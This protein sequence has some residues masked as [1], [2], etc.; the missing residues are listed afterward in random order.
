VVRVTGYR[1]LSDNDVE[2]LASEAFWELDFNDE[3]DCWHNWLI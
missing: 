2:L 3:L 1:M